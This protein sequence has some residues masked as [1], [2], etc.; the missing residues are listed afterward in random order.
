MYNTS[1]YHIMGLGKMYKAPKDLNFRQVKHVQKIIEKDKVIK[2]VDVPF[3]GTFTTTGDLYE[4][5]QIAKGNDTITRDS[6][7]I[8]VMKVSIQNLFSNTTNT[9]Q[10]LRLRVMFVRSKKGPLVIANFPAYIAT[11]D[12]D[13]MQVY[14]DEIHILGP[15]STTAT[16]AQSSQT[17]LKLA[18]KKSFKNKKIPH[19]NVGYDTD[20]SVTDAQD[21]PLYMYTVGDSANS[22][23]QQGY[24]RI[25]WFDRD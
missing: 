18:Y 16:Q 15:F 6:D 1:H 3:Q 22:I 2:R 13:K 9:T 17:V 19:L 20:V 25:S 12:F 10:A 24:A 7:R 4:I 11:P 21:N 8:H 14:Y 5:T 23:G